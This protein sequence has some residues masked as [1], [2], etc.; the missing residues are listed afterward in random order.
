MRINSR[1]IAFE[2]DKDIEDTMNAV[3]NNL[4]KKIDATVETWLD[5][6]FNRIFVTYAYPD[7]TN[8]Q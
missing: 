1:Y 4:P 6:E 2:D 3:V 8:I 7:V 5:N